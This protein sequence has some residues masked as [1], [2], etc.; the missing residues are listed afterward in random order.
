MIGVR[1]SQHHQ[2]VAI[3]ADAVQVRLVGIFVFLAPVGQKIHASRFLVDAADLTDNPR[4]M[5]YLVFQSA[6]FPVV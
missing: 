4:S 1:R 2:V 6:G 5:G 3:E